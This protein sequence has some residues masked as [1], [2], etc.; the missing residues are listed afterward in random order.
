MPAAD[1]FQIPYQPP[2]HLLEV[3]QKMAFTE[4]LAPDDPRYV[5]TSKARGSQQTLSRLARKFR[6]SLSDGAFYPTD[7][8]HVLFFGH[9]GSGKSTELRQYSKQLSGPDRFLTLE[10]D[11]ATR[12]DRNNVQYADVLMAV[13]EQLLA[14]LQDEQIVPDPAVL[15]PLRNWFSERVIASEEAKDFRLEVESGAKAGVSLAGLL[16]LFTKFTAAFKANVTYKDSLRHVIRNSYTQFAEAFNAMLRSV[17]AALEHGGRARRVLF[18]IESTDKLRSEDTHNL[19]MSDVE[20]LLAIRANM[21][22]TAPLSL[23]YEGSMIG[24]L[25]DIVLPMIKIEDRDGSPCQAGREAMRDILLKRADRSLFSSDAEVEKLVEFS[26]GH[27]RELLRLLKLCCEFAEEN[28]VDA[29]TVD[30][31][32]NQLASEYRRFLEPA[33]YDLLVLLDANT[34]HAGNDDRT[35]KL[36]YNLS[37]LEYNDGTWR[38]SHPVI[39]TLE[40]Y[41]LARERAQGASAKADCA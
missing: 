13:A 23:K 28:V 2:K 41:A 6:L 12:L 33:D 1:A 31:S 21:I 25:D 40:G 18:V 38:R 14:R 32:V 9:T 26:G 36:L 5:D 20:Q 11:V 8:M 4:A 27:P 22:F 29:K 15:E 24:K 17:E 10:V 39:R 19:F 3:L 35:R 37:L 34:V 7:S 16:G 30:E